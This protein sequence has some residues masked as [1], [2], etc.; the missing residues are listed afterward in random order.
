MITDNDDIEGEGVPPPPL[1]NSG[2]MML[3]YERRYTAFG[4]PT[5]TI[6]ALIDYKHCKI[7]IGKLKDILGVDIYEVRRIIKELGIIQNQ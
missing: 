6:Q 3:Q 4:G 7:S 5:A 2:A 1:T